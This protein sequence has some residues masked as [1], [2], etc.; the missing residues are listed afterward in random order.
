MSAAAVRVDSSTGRGRAWR[1][2]CEAM[3]RMIASRSLPFR[4]IFSFS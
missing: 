1:A 3:T 4:E 2:E